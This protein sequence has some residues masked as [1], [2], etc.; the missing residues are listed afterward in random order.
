MLR[1]VEQLDVAQA[2][3]LVAAELL[4]RDALAV[5]P[6]AVGRV[7]VITFNGLPAAFEARAAISSVVKASSEVMS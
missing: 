2:K 7:Q 1:I 6:R 4:L 5:D 3:N